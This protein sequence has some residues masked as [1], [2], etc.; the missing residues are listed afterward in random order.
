[1]NLKELTLKAIADVAEF[2][3]PD[4]SEFVRQ[5]DPV[6]KI[7]GQ[8][9][10]GFDRVLDLYTFDSDGEQILFIRT[11]LRVGSC[12]STNDM[13]VSMRILESDNPVEAALAEKMPRVSKGSRKT[14]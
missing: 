8:S 10:I 14:V 12:I 7:L 1:M 9:Q 11:E 13:L 6:L 3:S 4:I 5:I 2:R